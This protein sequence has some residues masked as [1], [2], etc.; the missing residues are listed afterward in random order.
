MPCG[1]NSWGRHG[2]LLRSLIRTRTRTAGS[3]SAALTRAAATSSPSSQSS[4]ASTLS[5]ASHAGLLRAGRMAGMDITPE[6]LL[7]KTDDELVAMARELAIQF[8]LIRQEQGRRIASTS[9]QEDTAQDA[10][11]NEGGLSP[12]PPTAP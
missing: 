11:E 9:H 5:R 4:T 7:T 8:D 3:S 1:R 2:G 10:E 12:N 6:T